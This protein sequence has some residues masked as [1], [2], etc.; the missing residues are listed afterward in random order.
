V[1]PEETTS[2]PDRDQD[3]FDGGRDELCEGVVA[4]IVHGIE[5]KW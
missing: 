3:W 2:V 1:V 5:T 4:V